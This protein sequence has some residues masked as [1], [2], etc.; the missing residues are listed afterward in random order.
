MSPFLYTKGMS[1]DRPFGKPPIPSVEW[2]SWDDAPVNPPKPAP[3]GSFVTWDPLQQPSYFEWDGGSVP[4][5][6]ITPQ[7]EPIPLMP[8]RVTARPPRSV[9]A[10]FRAQQPG[11]L[12]IRETGGREQLYELSCLPQGYHQVYI[13]EADHA[14]SALISA[15][16]TDGP[17]TG[18]GVT[19]SQDRVAMAYES[20]DGHVELRGFA[21]ADGVGSCALSGPFAQLLVEEAT[22][23]MKMLLDDPRS[24]EERRIAVAALVDRTRNMAQGREYIERIGESLF[25]AYR[26]QGMQED[27]ARSV[28][29][30]KSKEW[31]RNPAS[32]AGST[33]CVGRWE[34][35]VAPDGSREM[36]LLVLGDFVGAVYTA[37]GHLVKDLPM[38]TAERAPGQVAM[39]SDFQDL[40]QLHEVRL[41]V[42]E[43]GWVVVSTD[44]LSEERRPYIHHVVSEC[45]QALRYG[46]RSEVSAPDMARRLVRMLYQRGTS[47]PRRD[48][49]SDDIGIVLVKNG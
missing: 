29:D 48:I 4:I 25:A 18:K 43:N 13:A 22:A 6:L 44:G 12:H 47:I 38:Q 2:G 14:S 23:A 1:S 35:E 31:E 10:F 42:P 36:R 39:F 24:A 17:D 3:Q 16:V 37:D 34:K 49:R 41:R 45:F 9:E 46:N 21:L 40:R 27:L 20:R 30:D 28:A 32:I 11:T 7:A 26:R 19:R 8:E 33:L 5:P 15:N